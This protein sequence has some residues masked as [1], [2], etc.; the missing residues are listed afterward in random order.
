MESFAKL[1][2]INT[3]DSASKSSRRV[4]KNNLGSTDKLLSRIV[5]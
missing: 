3:Y 5:E 2:H 1:N 4:I